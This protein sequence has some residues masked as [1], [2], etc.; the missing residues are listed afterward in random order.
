MDGR[1]RIPMDRMSNLPPSIIQNILALMPM[2]DAF[3]TS[4]LSRNWRYHCRNISKLCFDKCLFH[5]RFLHDVVYPVLL[6]HQGPI[7]EFSLCLDGIDRCWEIDQIILH[8]S[9]NYALKEFQLWIWSRDEYKLL[10][11]FFNLQHLTALKL[12]NCAF[13]PPVTFKGF[14]RLV[15]LHFY[16]VSITA[17]VFLRFISNC[18]LLK[19]FTLIGDEKHFLGLWSCNFI[20][21]F[22]RLPLVERLRMSSYSIQCFAKGVIPQKLQTPLAHLRSLDLQESG[23]CFGREV[24]L[25][26]ILLLVTSSPNIETIKLEMEDDPTEAVSQTIMNLIDHQDYSYVTLDHLRVIEIFSFS[27]MK[28][29]MDFVKLILAKSPMLKKAAIHLNEQVVDIHGR[30]KILEEMIQYPRASAKAAIVIIN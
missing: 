28:T 18:P 4:I 20:E 19:D 24:D 25:L 23:L 17:E 9:R 1:R 8:L 22:E 13:Q 27:N 10:P 15:I 11:A 29:G 7:L 5:T 2:P 14:E 26:S 16:E 21:L 12:K 30:V 6:L 3:R